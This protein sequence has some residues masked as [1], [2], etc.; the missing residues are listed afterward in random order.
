MTKRS[1]TFLATWRPA[2]G[3]VRVVILA[4]DD[5]SWRAFLG[6]D[7]Q[8][9]V[10]AIVPTVLDR[11]AIEQD[12]HDRK[13]VERIEQGQWRRVWSNVGALNLSLGVHTLTEVWGWSRPAEALSD[14]T[15][16]PWEDAERRPSQADRRKALQR[17]MLEEEY[18][19]IGVPQP[20]SEKIRHL[21]AGVVRLAA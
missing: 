15:D 12:F 6:T 17:E 2:G 3:V 8:A 5:G 18:R 21:L 16:S 1:K 20:W 14:R 10:A 9:S 7:A 13:E 11:W 4:A 19:R